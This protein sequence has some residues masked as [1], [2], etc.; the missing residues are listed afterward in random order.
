MEGCR[1]RQ[2]L[3]KGKITDGGMQDEGN[4]WCRRQLTGGMQMERVQGKVTDGGMGVEGDEGCRERQLMGGGMQVES[5][6]GKVT[7]GQVGAC[8]WKRCRERQLMGDRKSHWC[9]HATG[10]GSGNGN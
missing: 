6:Q 10:R 3:G 1:E 9:G 7:S 2:L 4:K 5:I 8:N